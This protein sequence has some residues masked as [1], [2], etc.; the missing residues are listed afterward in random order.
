MPKQGRDT[1]LHGCNAFKFHVSSKDPSWHPNPQTCQSSSIA[2]DL[3]HDTYVSSQP[4]HAV[5]PQEYSHWLVESLFSFHRNDFPAGFPVWKYNQKD[6][7]QRATKL[8][9]HNTYKN[10]TLFTQ[11]LSGP[12]QKTHHSKYKSHCIA[13]RIPNY[14]PPMMSIYYDVYVTVLPCRV[15]QFGYY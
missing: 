11:T 1:P 2:H 4:C 3:S 13:I 14:K 10:N 8:Q 9:L 5:S 6:Q 7:Q 15:E 12:H